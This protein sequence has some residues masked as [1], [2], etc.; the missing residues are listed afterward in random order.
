M[1]LSLFSASGFTGAT[2]PLTAEVG[3][4]VAEFGLDASMTGTDE[5]YDPSD[6]DAVG[7]GYHFN[8]IT[9]FSTSG[10][11]LSVASGVT[12]ETLGSA[13]TLANSLVLCGHTNANA[14]VVTTGLSTTH[15]MGQVKRVNVAGDILASIAPA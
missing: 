11:I 6:G 1:S 13:T 5:F 4:V 10:V 8:N 7:K 2:F 15:P 3:F 12:A 14:T 9:T